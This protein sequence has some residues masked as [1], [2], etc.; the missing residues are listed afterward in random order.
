MQNT[1]DIFNKIKETSGRL[2]KE[3]I[4]RDNENNE[5]F[6]YYLKFL[7]D[8]FII[9]GIGKKKLQKLI[10]GH[11]EKDNIFHSFKAVTEYVQKNN[12]GT[13]MVVNR[14]AAF[15][16]AQPE[17][18]QDF[19]EGMVKKDLKI[20]L[21][22]NTVNKI[23]GKGYISQFKVQLA[24]KFE[25]EAEKIQG[26][27][28]A[29]TEKLDGQRSL[30]FVS[31]NGVKMFSRT[32]QPVIGLVDIEEE[33]LHLPYGV[34]DGEL[35]IANADNYKDRGVLQETLKITRKE[36]SEKT[37]IV[38]HVFDY[39]TLEE[40]DNGKSQHG[41]DTRRVYIER[42]IDGRYNW[43]KTLPVLYRGKDQTVIP[44]LL[45]ELEDKGKEGLMLNVISKPWV[46]KRTNSL[47]KIKSMQT[48]DLMI[49][50]FVE[51]EG[52]YQGMLGKIIV[53]YK[54]FP[55]GCGSG[56]SDE[57]REYIWNNQEE[58]IGRICEIQYFR[59]ST[60]DNGGISVSFPIFLEMRPDKTEP[61]YY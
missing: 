21:T 19:F 26:K 60:N 28:F 53:G 16:K 49:T 61:S 32:G 4:L 54:G 35:L 2:D 18:Q 42:S 57:Q 9:T 22:G 30:I 59:E 27:G 33:A 37:G 55:L 46:N 40:F 15:I 43:I 11:T 7:L 51:G 25:D 47:L 10:K 23:Y 12:T 44:K 31:D 8:P 36:S 17:S 1:I 52:K 3:Q 45:K 13:D 20:G 56:F 50:D 38:L 6:K 14:V 39:V 5:E 29:L 48:V 58:F 41:Y 34:Y 24:K